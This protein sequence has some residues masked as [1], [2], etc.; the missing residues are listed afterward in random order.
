MTKQA[1][2]NMVMMEQEINQPYFSRT[3]T[4]FDSP[5]FSLLFSLKLT[6]LNRMALH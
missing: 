3:E 4:V 6:G 5:A 2:F 1:K